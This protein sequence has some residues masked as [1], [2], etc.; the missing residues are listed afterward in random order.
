MGPK[1]KTS[2]STTKKAP[3]RKHVRKEVEPLKE[4]ERNH[5]GDRGDPIKREAVH[6][7]KGFIASAAKKMKSILKF[8]K[9]AVTKHFKGSAK[10]STKTSESR[11]NGP[12]AI[13]KVTAQK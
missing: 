2:F 9:K 11:N 5:I 4:T 13:E 12:R 7:K 10:P 3:E 8:A 1:P 6:P